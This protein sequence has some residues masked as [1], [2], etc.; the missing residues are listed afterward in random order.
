MKDGNPST[1]AE[2]GD[3]AT[4]VFQEADI[5]MLL[6]E[7]AACIFVAAFQRERPA[8]RVADEARSRGMLHWMANARGRRPL[9]WA[10]LCSTHVAH[11]ATRD[12]MGSRAAVRPTLLQVLGVSCFGCNKVVE[13]ARRA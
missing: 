11:E 5:I 8:G 4:V 12:V 10:P 6:G 3:I 1:R 7:V 9:T 13:Q 2:I